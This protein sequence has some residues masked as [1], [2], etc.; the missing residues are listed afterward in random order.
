MVQMSPLLKPELFIFCY[1]GK[2][3]IGNRGVDSMK[4]NVGGFDRFIRI[5]GGL[6]IISLAFWGPQTAWA[7]LGVIPLMT[8]LFSTCGL[9]TM[10][11]V[12]TCK[13]HKNKT[14]E[15]EPA[16]K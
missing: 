6:F 3:I 5:V 1:R 12:S 15:A 7:Y 9:Y 10:F 11:G 13:L 2:G 8:G 16:A 14:A 4:R